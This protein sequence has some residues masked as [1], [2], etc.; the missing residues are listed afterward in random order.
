MHHERTVNGCA[1]VALLLASR[2]TTPSHANGLAASVG[3]SNEP[4]SEFY[5]CR[6]LRIRYEPRADIHQGFR[7]LACSLICWRYVDRYC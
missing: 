7:L 3:A 4:S 1:G 6:R 5:R 2:D